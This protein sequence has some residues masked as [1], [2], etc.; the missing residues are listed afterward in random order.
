M[1]CT[2]TDTYQVVAAGKQELH[3]SSTNTMIIVVVKQTL[4]LGQ[5]L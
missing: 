3:I 2:T 4:D 1:T 5:T